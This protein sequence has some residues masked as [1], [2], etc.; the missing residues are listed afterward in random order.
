MAA[1]ITVKPGCAEA[2]AAWIKLSVGSSVREP[3]EPRHFDLDIDLKSLLPK[4]LT[5]LRQFEPFGPGA[6]APGFLARGGQAGASHAHRGQE[7]TATCA[8]PWPWGRPST[9][10]CRRVWIGPPVGLPHWS[11]RLDVVFRVETECCRGVLQPRITL[12]DFWTHRND[13]G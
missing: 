10:G 8:S 6:P 4:L 9:V 1:G 2:F 5:Q 11:D 7:A 12:L 13:R 3:K